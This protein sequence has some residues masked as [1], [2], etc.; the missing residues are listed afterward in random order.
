MNSR[1]RKLFLALLVAVLP[2]VSVTAAELLDPTS[3]PKFVNPLPIPARIE[4]TAGGS[5]S[6]QA[7]ETRQWLGLVGPGGDRLTTKVWGYGMSAVVPPL[8]HDNGSGKASLGRGPGRAAVSYP[9]PTFV[10]REGTPVDVTWNNNLPSRHLLPIDRTVM[11]ANP[12]RGGIPIVTHLHGGHSESASDGLPEAWFTQGFRETGPGWVKRKLTYDNDQEAA[13]LWYHDH[14]LGITRL[15]VYAG[16]AGF[17]LLRD[18]NED[19]LTSSGVLPGGSYEIEIA[20][21]DRMFTTQG[22]LYY[23]AES[24]ELPPGA[25]APSV[26]PE[27]FGDFIIVNGMTWPVLNVEPRQYRLRYLNGSDSRFYVL[28]FR[29]ALD[30]AREFL[31]IGTDGGLL[32]AAVPLTQLVIGP[33][34][35]A[36]LVVDFADLGMGSEVI[37]RNFGPDGPFGEVEVPPD[38]LAD[39]ATTGQIMKFR[40]NVALSGVPDATV[41]DGTV[42]RV[43]ITPFVQNGATRELLLFEGVDEYGRLMPML[44]TTVDGAMHFG[45]MVTENPMLNDVEVWEVFNSTPDAHPIHLHLVQFQILDRQGFTADQDP[46][47]GALSNIQL[48]GA[49]EAPDANEQGF[50][51]TV[52]MSP[53]TV[54]RV[55]AKFDREGFYVWHC[56][57]LS[58]EDHDM[59]RPYYVGDMPM[60]RG[61]GPGAERNANAAWTT[62]LANQPNPFNPTTRI[63]FSVPAAGHAQIAIFNVRGERVCTLVDGMVEAGLHAATWNGTDDHG[64]GVPSGRYYA[65]LVAGKREVVRALTLVR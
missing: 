47:T 36:D 44:G 22:Q 53:G 34:E 27:F 39:P 46:D 25:P 65:H 24:D 62:T 43:P 10:A 2:A 16:L 18:T 42:L 54:T 63:E 3:H 4:A 35:R 50:K 51:D 33:G 15:N 20:I 5:F 48:V 12:A 21:Q 28:E 31:Q 61:D 6:M 52:R 7:Q 45:M 9:G 57:I 13:T 19:A 23:P 1:V 32:D 64:R 29:D 37:L 55:I 26:L 17:Y 40:V 58:H 8:V 14:A 56:H 11:W 30:E 38:D 60:A 49:P 41:A 59:M